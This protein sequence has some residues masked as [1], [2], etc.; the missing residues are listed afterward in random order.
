[1]TSV[2]FPVQPGVYNPILPL[3]LATQRFST[4]RPSN[5][6]LAQRNGREAK[7]QSQ[8]IRPSYFDPRPKVSAVRR[9]FE[10]VPLEPAQNG[11]LHPP[12]A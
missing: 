4:P 2:S 1:M 9:P 3:F 11:P 7:A 5:S 8:R 10:R 6:V 12:W